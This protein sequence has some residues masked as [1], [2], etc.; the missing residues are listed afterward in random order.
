VAHLVPHERL[1]SAYGL[2]GAAFGVSWFIGS[3][4]LGAAYDTSPATAALVAAIAQLLAIAPL[5]VSIR[6]FNAV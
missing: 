5:A 1:G 3:V 6:R 2:F 4:V